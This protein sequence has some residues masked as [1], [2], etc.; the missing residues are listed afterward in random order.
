MK[1]LYSLSFPRHEAELGAD[2]LHGLPHV[3]LCLTML[4]PAVGSRKG[5]TELAFLKESRGLSLT[6]VVASSGELLLETF[7]GKWPHP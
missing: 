2:R 6:R 3:G 4:L 5:R 7:T 1:A